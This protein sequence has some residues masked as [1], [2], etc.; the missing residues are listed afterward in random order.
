M[1]I[2]TRTDRPAPRSLPSSRSPSACRNSHQ[3]WRGQSPSPPTQQQPP[4]QQQDQPSGG[5]RRILGVLAI[6][7]LGAFFASFQACSPGASADPQPIGPQVSFSEVKQPATTLE[8]QL[9]PELY[10]GG[11]DDQGEALLGRP[12]GA[13]TDSRGEVYVLDIA[14][15][16]FKVYSPA[17]GELLRTLGGRGRGEGEFLNV[18]AFTIDRQDRLVAIDGTSRKIVV[19]DRQGELLETHPIDTI[20]MLWPRWL[21]QLPD[22]RF[23]FLYKMPEAHPNGTQRPDA[24][25]FL[26]LYSQDLSTKL[27]AFASE[28]DFG[29][30]DDLLTDAYAQVRPG[31]VAVLQ[32]GSVLFAPSLYRGQIHRYQELDGQWRRTETISGY[33]PQNPPLEQVEADQEHH[34]MN[35]QVTRQGRRYASR[36]RNESRGLFQRGD[37]NLVH[38]SVLSAGVYPNDQVY[39]G[40]EIFSPQGELQGYGVLDQLTDHHHTEQFYP[41]W[42]DSSGRL[43]LREATDRFLLWMVDLEIGSETSPGYLPNKPRVDHHSAIPAGLGYGPDGRDLVTP[44]LAHA[45]HP[46][47]HGHG[48]EAS[49]PSSTQ[50]HGTAQEHGAAHGHGAGEAHGAATGH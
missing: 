36:I 34:Y 48:G 42:M 18:S 8:L 49:H 38:L 35:M 27:A 39:F 20:S 13:A 16:S 30:M 46:P 14:S 11:L 3:R 25:F 44:T 47:G 15:M 23:L 41:D 45:H 24:P 12:V 29:P 37:G 1:M 5:P 32:D 40:A 22:G 4:Q 21:Q 2:R 9:N 19:L 26:H 17:G 50:D 10:L 43:Y 28:D 7:S 6:L 31:S 33:V